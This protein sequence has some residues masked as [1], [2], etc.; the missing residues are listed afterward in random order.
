MRDKIAS[1]FCAIFRHSH[2]VTNCMG[3][4]YCA[5][6]KTQLGGSVAGLGLPV[7]PFFGIGQTCQCDLC[8][9]AFA[10]LN[11]IDT[12]LVK[13]KAV[14][15]T[16]EYIAAEKKKQREIMQALRASRA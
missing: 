16:D 11:F 9:Q 6:C 10:G 8:K 15:P 14:W 1:I 12:F 4:K 2:L 13:E 5:R 7:P 3:Y